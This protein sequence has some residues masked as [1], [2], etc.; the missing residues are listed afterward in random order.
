LEDRAS[1][2]ADASCA[3]PSSGDANEE[4]V[5]REISATEL[6]DRIARGDDFDLVDVRE[7]AEWAIAR[8][9]GAKLVPL[10]TVRHASEG[11]DRSREIVLYCKA[12]VRSL[13]A[14]EQLIDKGFT[15]VTNVAGGIVSWTRDVDPSLQ[16]Y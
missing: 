14:A 13:N 7:P 12:G 9:E 11:W 8:I 15:R 2:Y 3:V 4:P 5:I 6:A 1:D 10:A 16:R